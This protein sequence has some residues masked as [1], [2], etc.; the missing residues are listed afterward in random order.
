MKATPAGIHQDRVLRVN[1]MGVGGQDA[2]RPDGEETCKGG[3]VRRDLPRAT[4]V[5]VSMIQLLWNSVAFR[6]T[7]VQSNMNRG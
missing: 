5:G 1:E 4:K 7:H 3:H 6:D 2:E